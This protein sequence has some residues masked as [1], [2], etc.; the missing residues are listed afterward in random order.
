[1]ASDSARLAACYA[2][3]RRL[4]EELLPLLRPPLSDEGLEQIDSLIAQREAAMEQAGEVLAGGVLLGEL[5]SALED[6]L[7]QQRAIELQFQQVLTALRT[8]SV[9]AQTTRATMTGVERVLGSQIKS[10]WVDERR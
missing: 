1:M 3:A 7:D 6:L 4:G 9:Q 10:R 2:E 8:S 5:R